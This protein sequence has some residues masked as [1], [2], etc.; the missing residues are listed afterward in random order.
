[1]SGLDGRC[2]STHPCSCCSTDRMRVPELGEG[3]VPVPGEELE[4][5][6]EPAEGQALER[7]LV[8]ELEVRE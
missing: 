3:Q 2:G 7:V 5:V 6:L 4:Q 8:L 1:M